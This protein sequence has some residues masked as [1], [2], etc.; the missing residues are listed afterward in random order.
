MGIRK[1][2]EQQ[3]NAEDF[4]LDEIHLDT[5]NQTDYKLDVEKEISEEERQEILRQAERCK[6]SHDITSFLAYAS[7]YKLLYGNIEELD[8][9]DETWREIKP[10]VLKY[11]DND[12]SIPEACFSILKRLYSIFPEHRNEIQIDATLSARAKEELEKFRKAN[13]WF[14]Y[15]SLAT[16]MCIIDQQFRDELETDEDLW[17]KINSELRTMEINWKFIKMVADLRL[18][19]PDRKKPLS[20]DQWE[21][22]RA[23]AK[24]KKALNSAA[25]LLEKIISLSRVKI[26]AAD[27]IKITDQ[28]IELIMD[29]SDF[30]QQKPKRPERKTF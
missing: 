21:K 1:H 11:I 18:L 16:D 8:L 23:V 24:E 25:S 26:I 4:K 7:S 20:R 14:S 29:E 6:Q 9:G 5:D 13:D 15:L 30:K 3:K 17:S 12:I 19:F 10:L 2:F 28:G 22:M 27:K